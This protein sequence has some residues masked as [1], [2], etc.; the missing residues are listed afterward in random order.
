M[1]SQSGTPSAATCAE[2]GANAVGLRDLLR[3][4]SELDER[5]VAPLDELGLGVRAVGKGVLD[6]PARRPDA[7]VIVLV[8]PDGEPLSTTAN[9]RCCGSISSSL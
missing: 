1:S 7:L 9:G 2:F 5:S 3:E 6:R 8:V 4:P